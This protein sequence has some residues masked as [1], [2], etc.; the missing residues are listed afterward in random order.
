MS[1][2]QDMIDYFLELEHPMKKM[3]DKMSGSLE[4]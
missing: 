1:F 3:E 4:V 2:E